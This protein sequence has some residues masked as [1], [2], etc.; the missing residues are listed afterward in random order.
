MLRTLVL[1]LG[2]ALLLVTVLLG[3]TYRQY[4]EAQRQGRG[5]RLP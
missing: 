1:V 4:Q 3:I 5:I 2:A